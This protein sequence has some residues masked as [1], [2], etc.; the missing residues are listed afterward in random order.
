MMNTHTIVTTPVYCIGIGTI[1]EN[2]GVTGASSANCPYGGPRANAE[3]LAISGCSVVPTENDGSPGDGTFCGHWDETCMRSELMTGFL[4]SG[5][6]PLSRISIA[7]LHDLGYTV[8]YLPAESYNR[9][10]LNPGCTCT[11]RSMME[12]ANNRETRQLG[13]GIPSTQRRHLSDEAYHMAV[14]Y[15]LA[16][17]NARDPQSFASLRAGFP[18][19]TDEDAMYVGNEAV[20][21]FVEDGGAFFDV[22]V[23]VGA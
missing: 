16:V 6:N 5:L 11:R 15:G 23:R 1:W 13:L 9:S 20:V 18:E 2:K 8:N 19:D 22:V 3:Y 14:N 4:N 7:S 10:N 17:L 12:L 21:V